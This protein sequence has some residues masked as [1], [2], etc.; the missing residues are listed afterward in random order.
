[1]LPYFAALGGESFCG[2]EVWRRPL[3]LCLRRR[4][5]SLPMLCLSHTVLNFYMILYLSRG[6]GSLN[7]IGMELQQCV[8]FWIV[9]LDTGSLNVPCNNRI[10][11]VG[12]LWWS[13]CIPI[14]TSTSFN[15]DSVSLSTIREVC[16]QPTSSSNVYTCVKR[17]LEICLLYN[18][19]PLWN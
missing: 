12:L 9:V 3:N 11:N 4:Q 5:E 18:I 17:F 1:M 14:H 7:R 10:Y 16:P 13:W 6:C 19:V 2:M 15:S 8:M